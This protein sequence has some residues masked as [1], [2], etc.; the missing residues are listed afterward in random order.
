MTIFIRFPDLLFF[1]FLVS[2]LDVLLQPFQN[3]QV[4]RIEKVI[5]HADSD[6]LADILRRSQ[7]LGRSRGKRIE[8]LE[9]RGKRFGGR[10]ADEA[11]PDREQ[12][13]VKRHV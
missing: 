3:I 7:L 8:A 10:L 1:I 9:L 4:R 6:P 2:A 12:H 5:P 13:P 11:D